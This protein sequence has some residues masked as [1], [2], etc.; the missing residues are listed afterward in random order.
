M[1]VNPCKNSNA[2]FSP[3]LSNS[4]G[5]PYVDPGKYQLRSSGS[6]DKPFI[7]MHG[8]RSVHHS[9]FFHMHNGNVRKVPESKKNFLNKK[10]I[11]P[12]TNLNKIGYTEDPHERKEDIIRE[13]YSMS[14]SKILMRNQ[15]F[16]HVVRQHGTFYPNMLTF[17]TSK[18][19]PVKNLKKDDPPHYGAWKRGDLAHTGQNK[20]LGGHTGRSTEYQYLEEQE[21]DNVRYQKDVKGPVWLGTASMT[22]SMINSSVANN[23][24]N[25]N[26]EKSM[27][28]N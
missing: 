8:E 23:A 13:E 26:G 11:E 5:D 17:G 2:T 28:Y 10:N 3:L 15:P 21:Q 22:K 18:D 20:T 19:F 9:E 7:S 4:I 12:F 14:S 25:V 16:S 27:M 6:V 24:R 1:V